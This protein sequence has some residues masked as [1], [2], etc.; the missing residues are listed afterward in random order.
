MAGFIK[1]Y[2]PRSTVLF[3]G[4]TY[5][6][7]VVALSSFVD[8]FINYDELAASGDGAGVLQKFKA[9]AI[10]HVF[11]RKEIAALAKKAG[12]PLRVGT[13]NRLFHWFNCKF[14]PARG[15]A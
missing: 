9:D 2:F 5:T 13:T 1:K 4:R 10:V 11:P 7:D 8:G 12:I 3:M 15:A 6:R 14:Q